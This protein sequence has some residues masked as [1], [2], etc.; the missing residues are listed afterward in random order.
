LDVLEDVHP[1]SPFADIL[2]SLLETNEPWMK[3]VVLKG[4]LAEELDEANLAL[5]FFIAQWSQ[6]FDFVGPVSYILGELS[7]LSMQ[8]L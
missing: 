4:T 1:E 7:Q 6:L 3:P 8:N 5:L 2:R